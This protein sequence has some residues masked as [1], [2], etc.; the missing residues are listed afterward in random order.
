MRPVAAAASPPDR[1]R[2]WTAEIE[3]RQR[4]AEGAFRV[5]ARPVEGAGVT[6]IAESARLE[7]PPKR[8]ASVEGLRQAAERLE[9]SL[10]AA[11]WEPLP[12]GGSWYAKRFAWAAR[13]PTEASGL[14]RALAPAEPPEATQPQQSGRFA[15]STTWPAD[16]LDAWRCEIR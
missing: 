4:D 8:P 11:G 15:R 13:Q 7:W 1:T 10:L 6:T 9:A 5:V 2:A 14:R 12:R 16:T 3:W